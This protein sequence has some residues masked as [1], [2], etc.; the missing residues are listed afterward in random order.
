MIFAFITACFRA[1]SLL[2]WLLR[3][4]VALLEI[5][6]CIYKVKT[7]KNVEMQTFSAGIFSYI[8]HSLTFFKKLSKFRILNFETERKIA[9]HVY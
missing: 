8:I 5:M 6:K 7:L 1:F 9:E 3:P 4:I 2:L